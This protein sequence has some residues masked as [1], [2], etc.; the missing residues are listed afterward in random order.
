MTDSGAAGSLA[1]QR[2]RE[3]RHEEF[4]EQTRLVEMLQ[5]LL[6]PCTFF[7]SLEN[8]PRSRLAGVF[9]RRRHVRAGLPDLMVLHNAKAVFIELKSKRGVPSAAQKQ[10]C[11]ELR[12][13]GADWYLARSALAALT[14]LHRS[15][16]AFCRPWKPPL[17]QAWEGPF[18]FTNLNERLPQH[19]QVSVERREAQRAWRERQRARKA[20]QLAAERD[21]AA[22]G[23]IAA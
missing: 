23:D 11:A 12:A 16:V 14:A 3:G 9:Q 22:G 7:S 8:R 15:G 10:I 13:A 21:D 17:L 18:T 6:D 2:R 1:V 5:E 20:A 4:A 19:P